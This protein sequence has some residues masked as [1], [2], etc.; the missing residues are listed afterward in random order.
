MTILPYMS[1][2]A[3]RDCGFEKLNYPP[4]SPY[5]SL[6]HYFLFLNLKKHSFGFWFSSVNELKG[7]VSQWLEVQ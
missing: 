2:T 3:I 4:H 6:S 7:A 1:H 5:L